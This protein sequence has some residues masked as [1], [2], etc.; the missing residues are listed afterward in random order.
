MFAYGTPVYFVIKY[1]HK[2]GLFFLGVYDVSPGSGRHRGLSRLVCWTLGSPTSLIWVGVLATGSLCCVLRK[3]ILLSQCL[4][5]LRC[6]NDCT[7]KL[8]AGL[9]QHWMGMVRWWVY[10]VRDLVFLICMPTCLDHGKSVKQK[11]KNKITLW[12]TSITSRM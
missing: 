12:W 6:I 10:L 5:L 1:R 7:G 8:N 4:S 11:Q 9:T 3:N 2:T